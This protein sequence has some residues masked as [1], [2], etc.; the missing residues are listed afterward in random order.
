M[1]RRDHDKTFYSYGWDEEKSKILYSTHK[2][3]LPNIFQGATFKKHCSMLIDERQQ[4]FNNF[5]KLFFILPTTTDHKENI[6]HFINNVQ[7]H[8]IDIDHNDFAMKYSPT[9][10]YLN[11]SDLD[12]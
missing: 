3:P 4:Q 10:K 5:S 6:N 12:S 11:P 7:L 2:L 1:I 8:P 9:K